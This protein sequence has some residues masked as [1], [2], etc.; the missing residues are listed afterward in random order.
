MSGWSAMMFG[1]RTLSL[2]KR[3]RFTSI[4]R[5]NGEAECV[6][7]SI[8]AINL[9][10]RRRQTERTETMSLPECFASESQTTAVKRAQTSLVSF[11][12]PGS[13]GVGLLRARICRSSCLVYGG[14]CICGVPGKWRKLGRGAVTIKTVVRFGIYSPVSIETRRTTSEYFYLPIRLALQVQASGLAAVLS[15]CQCHQRP[16][17]TSPS[18]G[19]L[20]LALHNSVPSRAR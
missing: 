3:V 20:H 18:H 19:Y 13:L 1:T 8:G 7:S 12:S 10:H 11:P 14:K 4:R 2:W 9:G 17:R 16:K 5:L 15:A 6:P